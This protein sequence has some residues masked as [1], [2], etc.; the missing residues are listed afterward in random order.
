V[1]DFGCG[2]G[3]TARQLIQQIPRPT[4]YLGIDLHRGMIEWCRVHLE[5]YA[6]S[7][8]FIHHDVFN[9][10]FNPG[11]KP[12]VLPFPAEDRSFSLVEA[13]SVF[14]HLTQSQTE[15]YLHE[16]ARVLRPGGVLHATWFLFDKSDLPMLA[17]E[18]NAIYTNEFDLSSAV[19]Y[20]REW[21]RRTARAA[22]LVISGV[23]PPVVRNFHWYVVMTPQRPD[24]EEVP[25]PA[26]TAPRGSVVPPSVPAGASEIGLERS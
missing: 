5:A 18:Q 13:N 3:R 24:V 21:L 26:D 4:R 22:G 20:D 10:S 6:P 23:I 8:E 1:L 17:D 11:D 7:F 16:S 14:T 19:L 9:V 2:C 25:F 12:M 15:H